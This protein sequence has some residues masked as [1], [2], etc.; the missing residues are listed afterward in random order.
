MSKKQ[1][2]SLFSQEK[3]LKQLIADAETLNF[4]P[5][6]VQGY[7]QQ[8][9]QV[10]QELA[11]INEKKLAQKH[12]AK[13]SESELINNTNSFQPAGNKTPAPILSEAEQQERKATQDLILRYSKIP[14]GEKIFIY[15]ERCNKNFARKTMEEKYCENCQKEINIIHN[16][17]LSFSNRQELVI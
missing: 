5:E 12:R 14:Q 17:S 10:S 13:L 1:E 6:L 8:L 3:E 9:A 7:K 2:L 15:C 11:G 4:A 16:Q